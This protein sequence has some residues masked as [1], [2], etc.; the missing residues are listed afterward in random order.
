MSVGVEL[1]RIR[2]ENGNISVQKLAT[3]IGVDPERWRKWET[4][5]LNPREDDQTKIEQFFGVPMADLFKI[6]KIKSS[7]K[8]V[9]NQLREEQTEYNTFIK[10]KAT[11]VQRF[12]CIH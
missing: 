10:L 6:H 4:K 8:K 9:T 11:Y 12:T 1:K 3:R 2:T 7:S 5:N